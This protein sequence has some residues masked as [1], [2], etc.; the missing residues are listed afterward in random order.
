[1]RAALVE[2]PGSPMKIDTIEIA[3]PGPGQIRVAV[4]YCGCCHSDL[5]IAEGTFPAPTPIVLGH[6]ASGIVDAVGEGVTHLKEG[7]RV[8]YAQGPL[9]AYAELHVLPA[10]KAVKL[11]DAIEFKMKLG[12]TVFGG[13]VD[14]PLDIDLPGFGLDVD[15]GFAVNQRFVDPDAWFLTTDCPEGVSAT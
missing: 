13:G 12:G 9:G 14:I 11:P 5:S 6:E 1:M 8:A 10:E 4:K 15:G 3:D 2:T 7:D